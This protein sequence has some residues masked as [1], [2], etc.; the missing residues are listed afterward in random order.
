VTA[1]FARLSSND[2]VGYWIKQG[3]NSESFR[4]QAA[5]I[6]YFFSILLATFVEVNSVYFCLGFV[7]W[8]NQSS[9]TAAASSASST[10][11]LSAALRLE[12]FVSIVTLMILPVNLLS[13]CL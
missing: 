8:L 4:E 5:E 10:A 3:N 6:E 11:F 12:G 13:F 2:L 9:I 1:P 7:F